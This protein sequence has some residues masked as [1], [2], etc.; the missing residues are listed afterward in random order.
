MNDNN[1]NDSE[2]TTES[3][4]SVADTNGTAKE[5]DKVDKEKSKSNI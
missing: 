4:N 1:Q 5:E 3:L 2:N